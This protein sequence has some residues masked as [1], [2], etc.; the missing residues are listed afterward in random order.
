MM[1]IGQ[2]VF[3][4]QRA[5]HALVR[6]EGSHNAN[7]TLRGRKN[8]EDWGLNERYGLWCHADNN[9]KL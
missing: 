2:G 7:R 1:L 3:E 5:T 4:L 6:Q 8:V 9:N